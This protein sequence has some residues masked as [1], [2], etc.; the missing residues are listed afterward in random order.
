M[1]WDFGPLKIEQKNQK[2]T[3]LQRNSKFTFLNFKNS[4]GCGNFQASE[5]KEKVIMNSIA[6]NFVFWCHRYF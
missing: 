5:E 6:M 4:F 1:V 3:T 2:T